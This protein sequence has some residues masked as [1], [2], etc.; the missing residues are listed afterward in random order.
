LHEPVAIS[1]DY[2]ASR[3]YFADKGLQTISVSSFDGVNRMV[4]VNKGISK[5]HDLVVDP[6]NG[7]LKLILFCML[8]GIVVAYS[9]TYD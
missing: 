7:Y 4:L 6:L 2:I 5:P 1:V 8:K 9:P 3:I